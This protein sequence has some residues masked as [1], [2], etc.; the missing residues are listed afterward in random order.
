[1]EADTFRRLPAADVAQIVRA[2][3]P[4]VAVFPI[5][6]TRRWFLLEC[7]RQSGDDDLA[8]T[9]IPVSERRH[10]ELYR[11]FFDHGIDTLLTPIFGPDLLERGED[12]VHMA[13]DGL[14]RLTCDPV[15]LD[16]YAEYGVRVRF[17][18]DHRKCLGSTPYA[19]LSDLFDQVAERTLSHDRHRLFF[20]VFAH[21]A[22]ETIGELAIRYYVEHG[23]AP[24]RLTLIEMYY[25]EYVP[26]VDFF[27]GFDKFCV[28]DMP[29]IATG[30]EDLYFT[31]SPS[32]YLTEEQLRDI[33]YDHLFSRRGSEPDYASFEAG[34]WAAMRA[35]YRANVGKTCGVG[36]RRTQAGYWY[37]LP[38]VEMPYEFTEH[39][40]EKCFGRRP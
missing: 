33:L 8:S 23:T 32:P 10:I 37:P 7:A 35:F 24:D 16:F 13:A 3:G 1:L 34:E 27:V 12:Y 25:G 21:D 20:G 18:G 9:Y 2:Q 39:P 26:P 14:A 17:Y 22:V 30:N 28:F 6:G 11:L 40:P 5:N 29:L 38:Q 15:F 31:V 4:R 19:Y 36:A